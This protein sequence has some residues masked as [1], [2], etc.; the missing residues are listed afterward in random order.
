MS[1]KISVVIPAYNSQATIKACIKSVF[2]QTYQN[3]EVIVVN[4]GSKDNTEELLK[5]LST[6][7]SELFYC[8]IPNGG[9]VNARNVG[10]RKATGNYI[11]FIDSDDTIEKDFLENLYNSLKNSNSQI[12]IVSYNNV[13]NNIKTPVGKNN[14]KLTEL[15]SDKA[16]EYLISGTLF[17]PG[18]WG[19][20]FDIRLFSNLKEYEK[21][22]VNEDYLMCFDLF[23]NS[24]NIVYVDLPLYNYLQNENSV[25]HTINSIAS[26]EDILTVSKIIFEQS[27]NMPYENL[28]HARLV[29]SYI[30]LYG[31]YIL[32]GNVSKDKKQSCRKKLVEFKKTQKIQGRNS[33]LKVF[34]FC[35]VP[36]VYKIGYGIFDKVR[37]KKLDPESVG[38]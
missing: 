21:V 3:F 20:L 18:L 27:K 29:N 32:T 5:A 24:K 33:K 9:V 22:K 12:S 4:D 36:F 30:E 1:D 11:T 26:C 19:K 7:Y 8:T 38:S 15:T 10:R 13:E 16:C 25:T 31:N 37:V 2:S 6:T 34:I 35:Y 23:R 14:G 28:A 17:P